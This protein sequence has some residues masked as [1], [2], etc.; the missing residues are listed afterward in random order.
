[1]GNKQGNKF[2]PVST[3]QAFIGISGYLSI[4]VGISFRC[5]PCD[6]MLSHEMAGNPGRRLD[7]LAGGLSKAVGRLQRRRSDER[8]VSRWP[9]GPQ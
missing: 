3:A 1:M 9:R 8:T 6:F 4:P 2:P 7:A 5:T